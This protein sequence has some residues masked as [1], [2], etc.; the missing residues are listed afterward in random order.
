MIKSLDEAINVYKK[1]YDLLK[2]Y[3]PLRAAEYKLLYEWLEDYKRLKGKEEAENKFNDIFNGVLKEYNHN[4][5][6][7]SEEAIIDILN[8]KKISE[9]TQKEIDKLLLK[10]EKET[11]NRWD[12]IKKAMKDKE[13]INCQ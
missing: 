1:K 11:Y 13:K 6:G 3:D 9:K 5:D 4:D 2:D 8:N 10:K 7:L 12:I